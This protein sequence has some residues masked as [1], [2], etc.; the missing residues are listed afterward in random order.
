MDAE[1]KARADA[2]SGFSAGSPVLPRGRQP[3]MTRIGARIGTDRG[4][5]RVA[6]AAFGRLWP[7]RGGTPRERV[8]GV[9]VVDRVDAVRAGGRCAFPV[10][11]ADFRFF[12]V[13]DA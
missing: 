4:R 7:G 1:R 10:F 11:S 12:V 9:D 8:D 2:V 13:Q 6:V 5:S 3:R